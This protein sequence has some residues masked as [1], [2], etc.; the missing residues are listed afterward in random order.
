MVNVH[1]IF[2]SWSC[3]KCNLQLHYFHFTYCLDTESSEFEGINSSQ[4]SLHWK[5]CFPS[6]SDWVSKIDLRVRQP[7]VLRPRPKSFSRSRTHLIARTCVGIW[8][9]GQAVR[10]PLIASQ[11][12]KTHMGHA[13]S[14]TFAT[15]TLTPTV[16]TFALPIR[17]TA[18][19]SAA[20]TPNAS[21]W[22]SI[23]Y[24]TSKLRPAVIPWLLY[25]LEPL[26]SAM[27]HQWV[28]EARALA[29]RFA[30]HCQCAC[31]STSCTALCRTQ[32]TFFWHGNTMI[33]GLA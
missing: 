1:S 11:F 6:F 31:A 8:F 16:A 28:M 33:L 32:A 17:N 20:R 21:W 3:W 12:W 29:N 13:I 9:Y 24:E 4:F 5:A 2:W 15:L 26:A 23:K 14:V 19:S 30:Y 10:S 25:S 18:S 7:W 22:N 27:R